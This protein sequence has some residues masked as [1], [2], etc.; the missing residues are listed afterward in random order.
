MKKEDLYNL[1]KK[2]YFLDDILISKIIL[3]NEN[4]TLNNLFLLSEIE[5]VENILNDFEKYKS[6][7]PIEYILWYAEF[8][9]LTFFVDNRVLIPRNDTE[10]LVSKALEVIKEQWNENISYIDVWSWSWCIPISLLKNSKF[11]IAFWID[12][13]QKALEVFDINLKKHWVENRIKFFNSNLLE[14]FLSTDNY[15]INELK[16]SNLIITAN[17]PYIKN[18]DLDNMDSWVFFFEPNIALFWGKKTWFE[19]YEKLIYQ[20]FDL[21]KIYNIKEILLFIEIGFDQYEYSKKYLENLWLKHEYFK[22][23]SWI[24]RLIKIYF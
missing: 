15:F 2:D 4:I 5:N 24:F 22:D 17:L 8:F 16:D 1:W 11:K 14:V 21:K 7:T 6:W 13:S 12:L 23:M 3:K 20:I 9:W 10:I 18:E 19:L